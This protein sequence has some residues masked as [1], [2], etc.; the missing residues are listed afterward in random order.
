MARPFAQ[1][2]FVWARRRGRSLD[3]AELEADPAALLLQLLTAFGNAIG[4]GPHK[5]IES[6]EHAPNVFVAMV[7]R[8]SKARKGTSF[9]RIRP[10]MRTVDADWEGRR[11]LSGLN[12]GEGLVWQVRD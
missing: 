12:S 5:L 4:R 3:R 9:G 6:D 11:I 1:R 2:G 8:T 7:G 10:L